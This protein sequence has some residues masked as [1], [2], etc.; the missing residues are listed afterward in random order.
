MALNTDSAF[1]RKITVDG[2]TGDAWGVEATLAAPAATAVPRMLAS[3]APVEWVVYAMDGAGASAVQVVE[4]AMTITTRMV[5]LATTPGTSNMLVRPLDTAS[6]AIINRPVVED[7]VRH[8]DEF[9]LAIT[10]ISGGTATHIWIV[11]HSGFVQ[12]PR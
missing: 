12:E 7:D 8:G 3:G 1:I 11:P 4:T 5:K 6:G 9:V 2:Y 10:A